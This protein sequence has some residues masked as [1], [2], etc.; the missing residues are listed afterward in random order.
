MGN[1][2]CSSNGDGSFKI[3][4][5]FLKLLTFIISILI[6]L[7]TGLISITRMGSDVNYIGKGLIE[8]KESIKMNV[9]KIDLLEKGVATILGK[10]ETI[11]KVIVK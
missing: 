1:K 2:I 6:L 5:A 11:Y 7:A 10:I 9:K 4:G 8:A 3:S